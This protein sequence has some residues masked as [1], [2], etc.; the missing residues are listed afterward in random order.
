M[1][2]IAI[3]FIKST[4]PYFLIS[5]FHRVLLHF[6]INK[7]EYI[8]LF[9]TLFLTKRVL[10]ITLKLSVHTELANPGSTAKRKSGKLPQLPQFTLQRVFK[11]LGFGL[12]LTSF[13]LETKPSKELSKIQ[14][15]DLIKWVVHSIIKWRNNLLF[16]IGIELTD[17]KTGHD[18][19]EFTKVKPIIVIFSWTIEH[20]NVCYLFSLRSQYRHFK[21]KK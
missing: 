2:P 1:D 20:F 12:Q 8:Y 19:S 14:E 7:I 16:A 3:I 18:L 9:S 15:W 4:I 11:Y 6:I 21:V 17:L 5:G 10:R 13:H